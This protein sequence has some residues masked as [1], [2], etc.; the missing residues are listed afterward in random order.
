MPVPTASAQWE[1]FARKRG[2]VIGTTNFDPRSFALNDEV[3]V[4]VQSEEFAQRLE[5]DFFKD[6]QQSK[7][8]TLQEWRDRP[9]WEKAVESISRLLERQQ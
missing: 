9:L 1:R 4:V 2:S 6:L 7:L 3:N 5:S 8:V